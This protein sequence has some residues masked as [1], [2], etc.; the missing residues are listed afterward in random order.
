MARLSG[1]PSE[2]HH[3][4]PGDAPRRKRGRPSK[5]QTSSQMSQ[6]Q[7]QSQSQDVASSSKRT[8][9][10]LELSQTKRAKRVQDDDEDQIAEEIQQSFSRSQRGDTIHVDTQ[11]STSTTTRHNGRR[12]SEFPASVAVMDDDDDDDEEDHLAPESAQASS[13][14]TPHLN[15]IGAV[16]R[17]HTT[18]RRVRHSLP[19]QLGVERVDEE[20]D[21]THFQY[22]PLTAVLDGRTR[23]RLRRSHLSQEVNSYEDHQKKDKK[24]MLQLREQLQA[25]DAKI[26]DLEYRLEAS[27]LGN[28]DVSTPELA[29]ELNEAREELNALRASS[30][31]NG[32]EREDSREMSMFDGPADM[33]DD[34]G[35]PM[36]LVHPDELSLSRDIDLIADTKGKY[37][38]RVEELSSQ[39]TFETVQEVS[40]LVEDSLIEDD[41]AIPDKIQDQAVERYEREIQQYTRQLAESQ[42]ALRVVTIAL[43]NLRFLEHGS[44]SN[45]ILVELRHSFDDLRLEIERFFPNMTIGLTNQQLLSKIPELFRG[46]FAEVK[47]KITLL[48]TSQKTEMLLR[49]QFEGVLDLLGDSE[50]RVKELEQKE[51]SLDKSNEEKQRTIMDLEEQITTLTE[52]TQGQETELRDQTAQINGL[53]SEVEEKDTALDRLRDA[54]ETYRMDLE[55]VTLTVTRLETEHEQTIARMEQEHSEQVSALEADLTVEQDARE[56]AET[57]ALQ[58]GEYIEDLDRRIESLEAEVEKLT[59][60]LTQLVQR[61]TQQTEA[62]EAAEEQRDEQAEIANE[63]ANTIEGLNETIVDLRA[64]ITEFQ[65]NLATERAQREKTEAALDDANEKIEDL[66]TAVHN[67]GIQANELRAK[68]FQLQQEKQQQIEALEEESQEREDALNN[69]I[70]TEQEARIVAEK[71]VE[72]LSKQIEDLEANLATYDVDLVNMTE[73]RQQ[74]E[75]DREQQVAVLNQQLIDL[76]AKYTALENSSNSTI[77]SLQANITDLSNQVQQQQVEI[78]RLNQVIADKDDLYEQ[79]TTLLKEEVVELKDDLAVERADNEKNQKEIASLSQ[80]VESEANELL[81]MMNSHSKES[82]ALHATISTLEATI[83]NHQSNAAEFAAEHEETVT[84]L[85]TE[86]EELKVMGTAQIETINTLTTQIEELKKRF[87]KQEQDTRETIDALT[88]SHRQLLEQNEVLAAALK[89]RNADTLKAVQDMKAAH[90][91]VK[92]RDVDLRKVATGKIVKTTEK[93]KVG[94]KGSKK[95]MTTRNW[96]DSGMFEEQEDDDAKVGADEVDED[97]LAA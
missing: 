91:V 45:E 42:G 77:E 69:Q 65:D 10:P 75:Q 73:A 26:K 38:Q 29:Q 84:T 60:E 24:Q 41:T 93:V 7:S 43:Q 25:Q 76:R 59:E 80:R 14:L 61:L 21:N 46:I 19:A 13:G 6:S 63:Y 2:H 1:L 81:S 48:S 49:R 16:K 3:E 72:K 37:S 57:D 97:F 30:L 47:E 88:L 87:A 39:M 70:D 89:A 92:A 18:M 40:Q 22:A 96:R 86:I 34:E 95:R 15:R 8:A 53:N 20:I 23:R 27:R 50:D 51:Y 66:N 35:Q 52:L 12:H 82:T 79:D 55:S 62:R 58:K 31:Y 56:A 83:K 90:V 64:Q 11:S 28:I 36:M 68:L 17:D 67:A 33:S 32:S 78:K 54:S 44:T 94:K 9:S 5:N 71:T 85:E 74:L 4:G